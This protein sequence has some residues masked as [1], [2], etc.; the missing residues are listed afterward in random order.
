MRAVYVERRMHGSFG[1]MN[2]DSDL[3]AITSTENRLYIGWFGVIMLRTL[4][5]LKMI[6]FEY[7]ESSIFYC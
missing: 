6:D 2:T 1:G 4:L 3:P 5:C 7:I